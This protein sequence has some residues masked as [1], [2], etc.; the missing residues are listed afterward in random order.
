MK[1]YIILISFALL[2]TGISHATEDPM[3]SVFNFQR[4]MAKDGNTAAMMK[5]GEMYEQGL[6]TKQDLNKALEMFKKARAQGYPGANSAVLRVTRERQAHSAA[7]KRQ[8]QQAAKMKKY[9][10]ELQRAEAQ[11]KALEER[12]AALE[13]QA[14][15]KARR[16]ALARQRAQEQARREAL[17]RQQ[18]QQAARARAAAEARRQAQEQAR[19]QQEQA[20]L[21]QE[22]AQAR[23]QRATTEKK[24]A[25]KKH[26]SFKSNPCQGPAAR[27]MSTCN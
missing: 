2:V 17:A 10:Q 20:R 6:G 5:L 4:A 14:R 24:P 18:A 21:Q 26:E 19:L 22:Q 7:A 15:Q 3:V 12:Q 11:R 13:R 16:A 23:I 25:S 8:Q 27:V 1:K 9:Q